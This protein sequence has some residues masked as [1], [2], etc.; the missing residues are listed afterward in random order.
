MLA[1][2]HRHLGHVALSFTLPAWF[3]ALLLAAE[4]LLHDL[5]LAATALSGFTAFVWYAIQIWRGK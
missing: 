5:A 1:F 4:P 3:T 2:L